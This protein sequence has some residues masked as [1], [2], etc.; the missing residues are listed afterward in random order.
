VRHPRA[1]RITEMILKGHFSSEIVALFESQYITSYWS[2]A[3]IFHVF[4]ASLLAY[5]TPASINLVTALKNYS[6]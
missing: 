2:V 4:W 3:T 1:G 5:S 6:S